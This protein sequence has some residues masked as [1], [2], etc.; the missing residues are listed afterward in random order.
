MLVDVKFVRERIGTV[1]FDHLVGAGKQ[2]G[3]LGY[4]A[5][6]MNGLMD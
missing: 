2:S 1:L 4:E 3:I 6:W 5:R